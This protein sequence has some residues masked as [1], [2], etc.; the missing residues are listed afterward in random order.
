MTERHVYLFIRKIQ[1]VKVP[2]LLGK[3]IVRCEFRQSSPEPRVHQPNS[4]GG[5]YPGGSTVTT[6]PPG[7]VTFTGLKLFIPLTMGTLFFSGCP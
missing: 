1:S 6:C 3:F 5:Q 7:I 2:A 4:G